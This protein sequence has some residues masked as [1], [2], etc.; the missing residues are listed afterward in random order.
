MSK[1]QVEQES[2]VIEEFPHYLSNYPKGA[3]LLEGGSQKRLA[4][5]IAAHITEADKEEPVFARLIGLEG[6]WGS[7]KSNVI[8]ILEEELNKKGSYTFFTFDAWGNQEDLQRRTILELLT[9]HLMRPEVN[10]LTGK[11]KMRA[12]SPERNGSIIEKE[13]TW[14][15]KLESLLSRKSYTRDITVP[16]VNASTKWFVLAL[17]FVGIVVAYLAVNKTDIWW[18]DIIIALSPLIL[19]ALGMFV[20]CSSW[21]EMFAMYNTGD[22]SD[23]T[24]YVISEQ[25]PSVREFKEWMT[26][27]SKGLPKNEKLVLVFDNMDRLPSKKVHMFWSLIQ[28][29]FADDGYKN[30]WCIVPYDENH[31]ASVFCDE[32]TEDKSIELLRCYLNKTF[33]VV[34]RVPEPIVDDYKNIFETYYR[35]AF[36]TTVD[37][38]SL[39]LISQCY[40]HANPV[41]N[42]REIISFINNNVKLAKQ[43]KETISP[44]NRAVYVLMEDSMLRNP[45]VTSQSQGN[46]ETKSVSTDEYILSN[47]YYI[48]FHQILMGKVKLPTMQREMAAMAY[49]IAPENADQIVIK[50]YIRNCISGKIKDGNLVKYAEHPHF[51]QRLLEDVK[52]MSAA[53]YEKAAQLIKDIDASKLQPKDQSRLTKI[54]RF[55]GDRYNLSGTVQ[56]Y[57]NYEQI[58]FSHISEEQAKQCITTFCRRLIDNKEVDGTHLYIELTAVFDEKNTESF[59]PNKICPESIIEAKRFAE[60][61]QEAGITYKRF[62]IS[63]HS[64]ELN[65]VIEEAINKEFQ[66]FDVLVLLKEDEKYKVSEVGD[67]SVQLLN[68]KKSSALTVVHLIEIQRL[69]FDKFQSKLDTNYVDTIWQEAQT[70]EGASAYEEIFTLKSIGSNEQLY[71]DDR[72][73]SILMDKVLFYTTTTQL[74]KNQL[75]NP[76]I[77]FRNKLLK[78]MLNEKKH[79][80]TPDYSEFIEHWQDFVSNLGVTRNTLIQ[81]ADSWGYVIPEKVKSK[82]YFTLLADVAWIDALLAE[83]TPLADSLLKKCV[84]EMA[85]QSFEQYVANDNIT[86]TGNIWSIALQKLIGTKY[87]TLDTFGR[88]SEIAV[89]LLDYAAKTA[90][91]SDSTWQALL[92]KVPYAVISSQFDDIRNHILNGESGY[93]MN[94]TKFVFLH[95]WL[96]Q[97]DINNDNHCRDAANQILAKVIENTECQNI[98]LENREY[99]KPIISKTQTS[100]SLL[101]DGLKRVLKNQSESEFAAYIR[102]CVDY[103]I[104]ESKE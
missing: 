75:A 97:S 43:W 72:H 42:I 62:P 24:S 41:P 61:V 1:K 50:R 76:N 60:Y 34:Y 16:S 95:G 91:I 104:E 81:F 13:C 77:S 58:L 4:E 102:E 70:E 36:G 20:T 17:L 66:Y 27:I 96:E 71:Q 86:H 99:Y 69:F 78:K 93:V 98:I 87:I 3:D 83:N 18:L 48:G 5:A 85:Q 52:S 57:S 38:E 54:W 35:E 101:H 21:R 89:S 22:R 10:K 8:K 37:D 82:P 51:M 40:R 79:D 103:D 47:E 9:R 92:A 28:T 84:T 19:F 23:T 88:M 29:F 63:T 12:M 45:K 53:E 11:T 64:S 65:K 2:Q 26:E 33:P 14:P 73:I 68:Q 80:D 46:N 55:L 25:E 49:G 32:V 6:K 67:F 39:E 15:E 56:E 30:I 31:L 90:P 59:D 74:L 100:A 44:I 7:G 94:P